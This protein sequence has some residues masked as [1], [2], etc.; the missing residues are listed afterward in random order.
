MS[1]LF[2]LPVRSNLIV[3]AALQGII[4]MMVQFFY[5]WRIH[6]LTKNWLVVA[7]VV[8]TST[9]SGRESRLPVCAL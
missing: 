1:T 8:L 3:R 5:A 9:V 2:L 4:S 7:V 6:V